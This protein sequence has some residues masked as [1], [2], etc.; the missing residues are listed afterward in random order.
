MSVV[1]SFTSINL[2]ILMYLIAHGQDPLI[3]TQSII[4]NGYTTLNCMGINHINCIPDSMLIT[5][6]NNIIIYLFM[7]SLT[8]VININPEGPVPGF[9]HNLI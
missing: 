9:Q 1:I 5:N 7:I 8:N 3:M 2:I 4:I 6:Y